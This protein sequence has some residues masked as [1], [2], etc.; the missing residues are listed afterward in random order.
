MKQKSLLFTLCVLG[1]SCL[2]IVD[3]DHPYQPRATEATGGMA[4][5]GG[6]SNTGG[7]GGM[8]KVEC[9]VDGDCDDKN[10][11]T[12]ETCT[13]NHLCVP[14]SVA[15]G[16]VGTQQPGDCHSITCLAGKLDSVIDAMDVLNDL[17]PCTADT[18][19]NGNPM[20]MAEMDGKMCSLGGNA[21][22]CKMGTCEITCQ[23]GTTKCD[24]MNPC[25]TDGC[26]A[27][28][29]KCT[30]TNLDGVPPPGVADSP[31]D[32][33]KH[34]C[35]AGQDTLVDANSEMPDDGKECTTDACMGGIPTFT[36]KPQNSTCTQGGGTTCDALGNCQ[37]G[38]GLACAMSVECL[39]GMCVDGVCCD[40]V[41]D[42]PC[43]SCNVMGSIGTCLEDP[44]YTMDCQPNYVCSSD[45]LCKKANGQ[46]CA[47]S[48]ECASYKCVGSAMKFCMP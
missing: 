10:P 2:Q 35:M 44:L 22:I 16:P 24:D 12:T 18:C 28:T 19:V 34:V 42:T 23:P 48:G 45:G 7:T 38:L 8:P 17:N 46:M 11:C 4:G 27:M 30:T 25:T 41:C 1:A 5:A 26:D 3:A 20:S 29:G 21:G 32:C 6:T 15:D 39:S 33:K 40:T 43:H 14:T 37:K 31:T 36:P 13:P 47:V 9:T